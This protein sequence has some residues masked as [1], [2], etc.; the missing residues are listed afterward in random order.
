[1]LSSSP[2]LTLASAK[3]QPNPYMHRPDA[4]TIFTGTRT[5]SKAHNA[6]NATQRETT[7]SKQTL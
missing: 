7:T 6:I 4:Y 2:V 5:L 3:K 1:M